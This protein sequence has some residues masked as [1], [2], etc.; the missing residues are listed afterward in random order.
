MAMIFHLSHVGRRLDYLTIPE[1]NDAEFLFCFFF[2]FPFSFLSLIFSLGNIG[3]AWNGWIHNV[4]WVNLQN[5]SPS[6]H[7]ELLNK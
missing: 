7:F 1:Q 3:R 2:L 4:E 5:G 6:K